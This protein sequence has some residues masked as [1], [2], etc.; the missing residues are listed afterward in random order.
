MDEKIEN[1][2]EGLGKMS[3]RLVKDA[4]QPSLRHSV[5]R[6]KD[7]LVARLYRHQIEGLT[8]PPRVSLATD[9]I[10]I[11]MSRV[12]GLLRRTLSPTG[13]VRRINSLRVSAE[14]L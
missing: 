3:N 8:Q 4:N 6:P 1:I 7:A 5:K 14:S 12:L 11:H 10:S 2:L 13:S 9:L